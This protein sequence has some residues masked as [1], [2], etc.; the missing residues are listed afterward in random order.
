MAVSVGNE[1]RYTRILKRQTT[2]YIRRARG[3]QYVSRK[4]KI[5]FV[6]ARSGRKRL[7]IVVEPDLTVRVTAPMEAPDKEVLAGVEEKA[8]WISLNLELMRGYHPLP[9]PFP[10]HARLETAQSHPRQDRPSMHLMRACGI[11]VVLQAVRQLHLE[12][13]ETIRYKPQIGI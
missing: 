4:R 2:V 10:L 5:H 11:S 12:Q 7:R 9:A 3:Q 1:L 13:T 6:L 8:A